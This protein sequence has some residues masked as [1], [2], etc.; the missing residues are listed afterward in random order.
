MKLTKYII[1]L[2][3]SVQR[4]KYMQ[5]LLSLFSFINIQFIEGVN[6]RLLTDDQKNKMFNIKESTSRYGRIVNAGEIG[7]ILSHRK[8]Y[9]QLLDSNNDFALILEDDITLIRDF[10]IVDSKIVSELMSDRKPKV[11]LLSGDYWYWNNKG[12]TRVYDAKSLLA[13]NNC[14]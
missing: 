8:C 9:K 4:K 11:L 13:S 7:C 3:S 2:K 10:N 1:N 6:G 14:L 12:I 5:D